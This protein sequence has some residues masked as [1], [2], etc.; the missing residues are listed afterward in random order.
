MNSKVLVRMASYLQV[1]KIKSMQ[2]C[3]LIRLQCLS[4]KLYVAR[5]CKHN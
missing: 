5:T 4:D 3:V 2:G 1:L